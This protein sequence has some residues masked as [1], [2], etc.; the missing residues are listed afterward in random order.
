MI[1]E[2]LSEEV[3]AFIS[4]HETDNLEKLLLKYHQSDLPLKFVADQIKGRQKFRSKFPDLVAGGLLFP[5]LLS[6]EQA[7]SE[8]TAKY[9]SQLFHGAEAVDLTGGLGIDSLYFSKS[10]NN[11][12]YTEK[13]QKLCEFASK[14]FDNLGV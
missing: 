11:V 8:I 7:S 2:L 13:D 4:D 12:T 6:G 1:E 9:K 10:F 14:N 5:T 3:L